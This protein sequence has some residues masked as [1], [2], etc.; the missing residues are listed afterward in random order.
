MFTYACL[1]YTAA[2]NRAV[3][4]TA[5]VAGFGTVIG[6]SLLNASDD[7]AAV[8]AVGQSTAPYWIQ[9][10]LLLAYAIWLVVFY[11]KSGDGE[12]VT[13]GAAKRK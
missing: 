8:L 13:A 6:L 2:Y 9:T 10:G 3:V 12:G 1:F 11:V 4:P 5:I 7:L